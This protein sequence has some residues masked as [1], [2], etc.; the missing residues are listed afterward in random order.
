MSCR[1][2]VKV[3]VLVIVLTALMAAALKAQQF[4]GWERVYFNIQGVLGFNAEGD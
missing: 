4:R 2:W 3:G 1:F